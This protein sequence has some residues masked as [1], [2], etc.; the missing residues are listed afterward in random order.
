MLHKLVVIPWKHLCFLYFLDVNQEKFPI[1]CTSVSHFLRLHSWVGLYKFIHAK[2][3]QPEKQT[4]L[5]KHYLLYSG[6]D[7]ELEREREK[8]RE[9][10]GG[11]EKIPG[12]DS[13]LYIL[14][15]IPSHTQILEYEA[16]SVS[17]K[18]M[19]SVLI[20]C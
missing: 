10:E 11:G 14:E 19:T 6:K 13:L 20:S 4:S 5:D 7:W 15:L 18:I 1:Q 3:I 8:E 17:I 16:N 9:K 12:I 2:S